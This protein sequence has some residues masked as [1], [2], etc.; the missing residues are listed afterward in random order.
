MITEEERGLRHRFM[1]KP[2]ARDEG[3]FVMPEKGRETT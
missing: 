3:R 2:G 1:E